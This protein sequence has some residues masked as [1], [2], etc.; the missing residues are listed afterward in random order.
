MA[1][2]SASCW[3]SADRHQVVPHLRRQEL[4][5]QGHPQR[6]RGG[7]KADLPAR[8]LLHPQRPRQERTHPLLLGGKQ[9]PK[10]HH[11]VPLQQGQLPNSHCRHLR[12][13]LQARLAHRGHQLV[14]GHPAQGNRQRPPRKNRHAG[15]KHP[16]T[17]KYGEWL[18]KR[19]TDNSAH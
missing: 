16:L 2:L 11:P 4:L 10:R 19:K 3:S 8:L 12:G 17:Q 5:P 9:E 15:G 18:G 14:A 6:G 7:S 1:R 13:S